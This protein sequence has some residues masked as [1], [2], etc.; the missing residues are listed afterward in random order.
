MKYTFSLL[1]LFLALAVAPRSSYA[2]QDGLTKALDK[3]VD[4]LDKGRNAP[5]GVVTI[6]RHD[7]I[8][9]NR[10]FG[11]ADLEHQ[12]DFT[13]ETITETGSVAKQFTA[14]AVLLLVDEGKISLDDDVRKYIP[15]LKNYG[16]TIKIRNLL[17]HTSG[18][19]DWGVLF[20]FAGAPRGTRVYT[21]QHALD[22]IYRQQTL[23]FPA[24]TQY[25]YSNS[26]FIVLSEVVQRVSGMPFTSFCQQRIFGPAGMTHTQ[27]RSDFRTIVKNRAQAYSYD[28]EHKRY[29]LD[30]PF[31]NVYAAGALLTTSGDLLN[32]HK[33]WARNGFG[34][35]VSALRTTRGQLRSGKTIDY[36]LGAVNVTTTN[37]IRSI[38]HAGLTA[39]Y[40]TWL[41][42]YPD[43]NISVVILCNGVESIPTGEITDA[44]LMQGVTGKKKRAGAR[45]FPLQEKQVEAYPGTYAAVRGHHLIEILKKGD[46]LY[47]ATGAEL[48]AVTRDTLTT[49]SRKMVYSPDNNSFLSVIGEDT[50]TYRRVFKTS[51][52]PSQLE[53]YKGTYYSE[54]VDA[55]ISVQVN[56]DRLL[57]F[58][59]PAT[60]VYLTPAYMDAFYMRNDFIRFVSDGNRQVTGFYI[61][62]GTGRADDVYFRRVGK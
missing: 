48:L 29:L 55:E 25:S 57:V 40:R 7:T 44:V 52:T 50:L 3:I 53:V 13:P 26:N 24:G 46:R 9:Y 30:M 5:G 36:A 11:S 54:E 32:W 58:R 16:D 56:N 27:W 17:T 33:C 10:A 45:T 2:Q 35:R 6:S 62:S 41:A 19:K 20:A 42:Y 39:G 60:R 23:N 51:L 22:I 37:G 8:L 4:G 18:L 38:S 31:D 12:V 43:D 47:F 14:T 15:E 28:K 1:L 49:G 34:E 59:R 21:M 61:S